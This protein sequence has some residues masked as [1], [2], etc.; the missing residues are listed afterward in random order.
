MTVVITSAYKI[1]A[2]EPEVKNPVEG[3]KAWMKG[4]FKGTT[5]KISRVKLWTEID[6]FRVENNATNEPYVL[7]GNVS[8]LFRH[9]NVV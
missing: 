3:T 7:I 1:Y 2:V 8:K 4:N 6:W 9:A 5:L